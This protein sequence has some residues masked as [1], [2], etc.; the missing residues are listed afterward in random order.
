MT[1][2]NTFTRFLIAWQGLAAI[3]IALIFMALIVDALYGRVL[4]KWSLGALA[5]FVIALSAT[6]LSH[7]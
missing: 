1:T 2:P 4:A 3:F 5:V 6:S 7:I